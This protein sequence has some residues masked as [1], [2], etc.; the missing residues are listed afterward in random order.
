MAKQIKIAL[1]ETV[2]A[3]IKVMPADGEGGILGGYVHKGVQAGG[4]RDGKE[5]FQATINGVDGGIFAAMESAVKDALKRQDLDAD[6]YAFPANWSDISKPNKPKE[7][8]SLD[9]LSDEL[10]DRF[11][12]G[13]ASIEDA[14][15][16]EESATENVRE[17]NVKLAETVVELREGFNSYEWGLFR[18]LAVSDAVQKFVGKNSVSEFYRAGALVRDTDLLEYVSPRVLGAKGMVAFYQGVITAVAH[19]V[20]ECVNDDDALEIMGI[21]KELNTTT[22]VFMTLRHF[23]DSGSYALTEAGRQKELDQKALAYA[24][25]VIPM[26]IDAYVEANPSNVFD[27]QDGKFKVLK[28]E[29]DDGKRIAVV[30]T[31][32]GLEGDDELLAAIARALSAYV[33]VNEDAKAVSGIDAAT[34]AMTKKAKES[35]T[36]FADWSNEDAALHVMNILLTRVDEDADEEE[37]SVQTSELVALVD[38]LAGWADGLANET[39]TKAD[40]LSGLNPDAVPDEDESEDAADA[41]E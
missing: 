1:N 16:E 41:A 7:P 25:L 21:G 26:H 5:G 6:A 3:S 18:K 20:A 37:Y 10:K 14:L 31:Q 33:K 32:F 19:N 35:K 40:I 23:V 36:P 24:A 11:T 8:S 29:G 9:E 28:I 15:T 39:I 12:A 4:K 17:A 13:Y 27:I 30:G 34:A 38:K 22:R 2:S